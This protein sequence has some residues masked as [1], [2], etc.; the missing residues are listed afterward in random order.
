MARRVP[1]GMHLI[2]GTKVTKKSGTANVPSN[3]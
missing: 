2:L 1:F 3:G